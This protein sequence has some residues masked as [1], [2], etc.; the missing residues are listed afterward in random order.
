MVQKKVAIERMEE[1]KCDD[2]KQLDVRCIETETFPL[3]ENLFISFKPILL[4]KTRL[5]LFSRKI[6]HK[7]CKKNSSFAGIRGRKWSNILLAAKL[8]HHFTHRRKGR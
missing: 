2:T 8:L 3:K 6:S 1:K 7:S 4:K 5:K